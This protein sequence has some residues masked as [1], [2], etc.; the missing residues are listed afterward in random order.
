MKK[1]MISCPHCKEPFDL[2]TAITPRLRAALVE[3]LDLP[4]LERSHIREE[5]IAELAQTHRLQDLEQE[6]LFSDL[7]ASIHDL[8][9]KVTRG[10]QQRTGEVL[11]NEVFNI[12]RGNFPHD[13]WARV[14]K[15][16][17]GADIIQRVR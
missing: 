11:E 17:T 3:H 15:G 13:E 16:R 4:A 5:V 14:G 9:L 6:K 8:H 2:R 10:S 7:R 12:L 1:L